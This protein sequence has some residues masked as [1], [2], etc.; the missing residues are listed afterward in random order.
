[1]NLCS[2]LSI[3]IYKPQNRRHIDI[4]EHNFT[5]TQLKDGNT[6]KKKKNKQTKTQKRIQLYNTIE[7]LISIEEKKN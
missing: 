2:Y 6:I 3:K 5:L 7:V 4:Y 1:M